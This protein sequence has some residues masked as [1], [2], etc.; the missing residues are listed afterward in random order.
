[1]DDLEAVLA[2]ADTDN[3]LKSGEVPFIVPPGYSPIKFISHSSLQVLH[4]CRRKFELN[5]M[6]GGERESTLDT[7]FGHA[8]GEGVQALLKGESYEQAI[9]KAF[10]A[11]DTDFLAEDQKKGKSFPFAIEA[12]RQ[13]V[14]EI[15]VLGTEW[16][17]ATLN[18][19]P[20][21]ELGVRIIFPDGFHFRL[22]MDA[23]L[24]HKVT[25]QFLVLELKTTGA[26]GVIEA[27]YKNSN[28]GLAY[29]V[30]LDAIS[31]GTNAFFVYYFAYLS[32]PSRQKWE[33]FDFTKDPLQKANWL[34]N[35]LHDIRDIKLCLEDEH[36]PMHGESCA[37]YGRP[38][39]YY[40][41]CTMSN[42]S[43]Y[44][45]ERTRADR[46]KKELEEP[47]DYTFTLEEI[48]QQQLE[49]LQS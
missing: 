30:A 43:L 44:A 28:Q 39:V 22:F 45:G 31:Q 35:I 36:F 5:R 29:A 9:F 42:K 41:A 47:Y 2:S 18:G 34:K 15:R 26:W 20:A 27:Q 46:V 33:F 11:W 37:N 49:I 25:K 32:Q 40:D 10:I 48:V 4:E 3:Y 12:I 16:E 14:P 8:V 23:V 1:M 21:I 7:A 38:C 17:L 19:R 6:G 13:F 24:Q